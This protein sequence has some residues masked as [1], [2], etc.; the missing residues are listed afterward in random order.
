MFAS[1]GLG[2]GAG[3][4]LAGLVD[5]LSSS[6]DLLLSLRVQRAQRI[7]TPIDNWLVKRYRALG[8]HSAIAIQ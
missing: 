7:L 6:G 5:R 4:K 1:L 2:I 8:K 3:D